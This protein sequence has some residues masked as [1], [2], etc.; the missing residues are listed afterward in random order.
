[1]R[2]KNLVIV[3]EILIL[4]LASWTKHNLLLFLNLNTTMMLEYYTEVKDSW[5]SSQ[6]S[7]LQQKYQKVGKI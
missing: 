3:S 5:I 1:M 7:I 6:I 2:L 4:V